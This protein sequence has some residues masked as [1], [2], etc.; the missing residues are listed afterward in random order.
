MITV[1]SKIFYNIKGSLFYLVA[2]GLTPS[3]SQL[4]LL[5]RIRRMVS[6]CSFVKPTLTS[7]VG[8][9][10]PFSHMSVIEEKKAFGDKHQSFF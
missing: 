8:L 10:P 1:V 9:F 7:G 5:L 6:A 3:M 2:P 4:S